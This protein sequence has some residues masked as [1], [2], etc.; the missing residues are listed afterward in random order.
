M[1]LSRG[2]YEVGEGVARKEIRTRGM[3]VAPG[4]ASRRAARRFLPKF[5]FRIESGI[6]DD[7]REVMTS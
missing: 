1:C 4:L 6:G 7:G 2:G 3:G 5:S